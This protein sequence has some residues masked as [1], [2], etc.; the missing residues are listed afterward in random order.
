MYYKS[1]HSP[2]R[3]TSSFPHTSWRLSRVCSSLSGDLLLLSGQLLTL[4]LIFGALC[5][6]QESIYRLK[7]ERGKNNHIY[8]HCDV[9]YMYMYLCIY[10][11][12]FICVYNVHGQC[13]M[14]GCIFV[15]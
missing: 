1:L 3:Q 9:I 11:Y 12:I 10:M 14:A 7:K 2:V 6:C 4:L 15:I 5:G 13:T 8:I